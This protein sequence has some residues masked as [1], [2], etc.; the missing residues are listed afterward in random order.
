MKTKIKK[1]KNPKHQVQGLLLIDE[2][3]GK[4]EEREIAER[5]LKKLNSL[6][7]KNGGKLI[8]SKSGN[9]IYY[10]TQHLKAAREILEKI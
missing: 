4:Y 9:E 10:L 8:L 2:M 7:D 6:F 3:I 5:E 1:A